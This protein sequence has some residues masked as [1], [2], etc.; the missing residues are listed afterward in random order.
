MKS[1]RRTPQ[2]CA[3]AA[4]APHVQLRPSLRVTIHTGTDAFKPDPSPELAR[5]LREVADQIEAGRDYGKSV[6]VSDVDD[7]AQ[8]EAK[9]APPS[10]R[11]HLTGC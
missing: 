7:L 5:I 4:R 10:R 3:L 1:A 9:R 8:R 6:P 2:R 11:G